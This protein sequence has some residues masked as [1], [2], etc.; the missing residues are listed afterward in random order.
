MTTITRWLKAALLVTAGI[1]ILGCSEDKDPVTAIPPVFS[2]TP[3][4]MSGAY[5]QADSTLGDIRFA[6]PVILPFG[7]AVD[8]DHQSRGIEYYTR[9]GAP[10]RAV[11]TG[12]IDTIITNP[13][14][15]GDYSIVVVCTP[16]SDYTV[17]QEHI[18]NVRVLAHTPVKP[19]D[20][21]GEAGTWSDTMRRT[22]L[23]VSLGEGVD[24]RY[25]CP[26][27]YG[28]VSFDDLHMNLLAEYRRLGFT[29]VY[30]TLCLTGALLP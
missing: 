20:T 4:D 27:N 30:D 16:G 11:T 26:L 8:P 28:S 23:K 17:Y 24:M 7:G 12:V 21:L 14:E 13:V 6:P 2:V 9:P 22:G 10:V 1:A 19:G 29:P 15:Q 18:I 5:H 3:V 25:Y